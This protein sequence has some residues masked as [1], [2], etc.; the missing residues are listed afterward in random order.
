[1]KLR[2]WQLAA[3]GLG[4][5]ALG[6]A[7]SMEWEPAVFVSSEYPDS[8]AK[9]AAG[10]LGLVQ[11]NYRLRDLVVAY[12]YLKGRKLSAEEQ[13]AL[14]STPP[15]SDNDME[16]P[17]G[18]GV[19]V[20]TAARGT[21]AAPEHGVPSTLRKYKHVY[22]VNGKSVEEDAIYLNCPENAFV[23]A[24][25]TAADRAKQWGASSSAYLDWLRGQDAV[26]ANCD[27]QP[28]A[29]PTD[30]PANAPTLLREDRAYQ[31]AAAH[32][33]R[34][35]WDAA[36]NGFDAISRDNASPWQPWGQYLAARTDV[37]QAY[38][39]SQANRSGPEYDVS[40]FDP[41]RMADA[42]KRLQSVIQQTKSDTMRHAAAM[43][44]EYVRIRCDSAAAADE[45]AHSL[46]GPKP[47][48]E[49]AQHLYDLRIIQ[50]R[51]LPMGSSDLSQW[52][53]AMQTNP[54]RAY[55]QW[56][57]QPSMPWLIAALAGPAP[58]NSSVKELL[59]AA[60]N[61]P[62]ASPAYTTVTYQRA[63]MLLQLKRDP[64][65]RAL[66]TSELPRLQN[67][68]SNPSAANAFRGLRMLTAINLDDLLRDAPRSIHDGSFDTNNSI[69]TNQG[70]Q[71][72]LTDSPTER[73]YGI[74]VQGV[75]FPNSKNCIPKTP[76]GQFADDTS[77][78]FNE[79]FP[80]SIWVDAAKSVALKPDHLHT[81]LAEAAWTRAVI[82]DRDA[83]AK[84]LFPLLPEAIRKQAGD[85][86]GFAAIF[87]ML[88]QSG[89]RPF[90]Q[91][92]VQPSA[93]SQLDSF[94]DNWWCHSNQPGGPV[95]PYAQDQIL[96]PLPDPLFLTADE[97]KR[98]AEET[99]VLE[100]EPSGSVW[101]SQRT[102]AYAREHPDDARVPE[103]LAMAVRAMHYGCGD[104]ADAA[105][106]KETAKAAFQLLHR[107]YPKSV[108]T[109]KTPYYY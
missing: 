41:A 94:R 47:D 38:V 77:I 35:E 95:E 44:L 62:T 18:V 100:K 2:G 90:L 43:E 86:T 58:D 22:Q 29:M 7:C 71:T 102:L 107:K 12:R 60:A 32:F 25:S 54:S 46:A 67:D 30:A 27:G 15:G 42:E 6:W 75:L 103:A 23:T 9:Y 20:W 28:T 65:A 8:P 87:A 11:G 106:E 37:R 83:E 97:K 104:N 73:C 69:E 79:R 53:A 51:N 10:D 34:A 74:V 19:P 31:I 88:H 84:A 48:P 101:L 82:L 99:A 85:G 78:L 13:A 17:D 55:A 1:M 91:P 68:P 40:S 92:G 33:Y 109:Q 50:L 14:A 70:G 93:N 66:L 45:I 76:P 57:A 72:V 96:W 64:E 16:L 24:A 105:P 89:L 98:A 26:F 63:R 5:C 3:L 52:I 21:N 39:E 61:V 36:R 80:L 81:E 49:L 56:K 4:C 59:D 108:W